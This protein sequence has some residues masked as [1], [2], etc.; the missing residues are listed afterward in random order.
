MTDISP[1]WEETL[2]STYDQHHW[3]T[4]LPPVGLT[5]IQD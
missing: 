5:H 4:A 1:E 2:P 3:V